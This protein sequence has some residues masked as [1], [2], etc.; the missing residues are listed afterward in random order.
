M[1]EERFA[2]SHIKIRNAEIA[3]AEHLV[4]ST[5][6]EL[7]CTHNEDEKLR[8]MWELAFVHLLSLKDWRE[9]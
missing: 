8:L 4:R 5:A 3:K 2:L 9:P 7:D 1:S 6:Y